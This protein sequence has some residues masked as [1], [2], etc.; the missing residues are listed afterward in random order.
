MLYWKKQSSNALPDFVVED[1]AEKYMVGGWSKRQFRP[2]RWDNMEHSNL[3]RQRTDLVAGRNAVLELLRSDQPV[4]CI[5]LQ[6][7]AG[8]TLSKIAAMAR[9]KDIVIKESNAAALD[10]LCG[11]A[12]HQGV[13]AQT[14]AAAYA[15]LD[16]LFA[17]AEAVGEDPFFLIADG[18]E[19]PHN[20]GAI[21]RTAD[22]AGAHGLIIPKRR[23]AGLSLTV[24]KT[25]AGAVAHLPVARV[26]NLPSTIA[27][28]KE[29]GVWVYA[30]DMQGQ[31]WCQV[32]YSGAV[33]LVVGGEGTG[34]S[35]LVR[36]RSDVVVSLPMRGQ[37]ASLNVSVA[38]GI[39]CYEIVRQR[40]SL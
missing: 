39:L 13:V 27:L 23:S 8:G 25:S 6:K 34:V 9:D 16:D 20:L 3:P 12:A 37:I 10:S 17:R 19:D 21:I 29:R 2:H 28:L 5:Y 30:A 40:L 24:S 26:S 22:A 36:E 31:H 15:T 35:R 38:T 1:A 11:N 33:A 32:D 4:E 7:R 18:V 14:A